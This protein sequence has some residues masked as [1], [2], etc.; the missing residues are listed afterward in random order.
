MTGARLGQRVERVVTGRSVAASWGCGVKRA[1]G[2]AAACAP[3]LDKS[4]GRGGNGGRERPRIWAEPLG[5]RRGPSSYGA[6]PEKTA[7]PNRWV[8]AARAARD[9]G[10]HRTWC[11][12][13]F[14]LSASVQPTTRESASDMF[15]FYFLRSVTL[16][17]SL[18]FLFVS[19][20]RGGHVRV[21]RCGASAPC[22]PLRS[23][24]LSLR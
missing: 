17:L 6:N 23:F 5:T 24:F 11:S 18:P 2:S 4:T 20:L 13:P 9:G 19:I 14:L 7:V 1:V 15:G 16:S 21:V 22:C 10:V 8:C 3:R 12:V